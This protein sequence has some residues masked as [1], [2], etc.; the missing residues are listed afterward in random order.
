MTERKRTLAS[1]ITYRVVSTILLM[2]LSYL[3]A[4]QLIESI[5][6]SVS[7]AVLATILFYFNDRA[8]E[9]TDWGRK[10]DDQNSDH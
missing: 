1:A 7:F 4:G 10:G 2:I 9:R 3:I 6:I 8:W 5:A